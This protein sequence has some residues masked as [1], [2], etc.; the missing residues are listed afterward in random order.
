MSHHKKQFT[1]YLF[2]HL[3]SVLF[4][5]FYCFLFV[6]SFDKK[7]N[8][9][10]KSN[11]ILIISLVIFFVITS[12]LFLSFLFLFQQ[13]AIL[14]RTMFIVFILFSDTT[15][16]NILSTSSRR[17]VFSQHWYLSNCFD[18]FERLASL[19][20]SKPPEVF[21]FLKSSTNSSC[22]FE[23]KIGTN[24]LSFSAYLHYYIGWLHFHFNG[25]QLC[26]FVH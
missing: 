5:L 15:I 3:F 22:F 18:Y 10:D 20:W 9:N 7:K 8:N 6:Q 26:L 13:N 14:P 24:V 21:L 17:N 25:K 11:S 12:F 23:Q 16:N 2:I 4:F 19:M 1:V